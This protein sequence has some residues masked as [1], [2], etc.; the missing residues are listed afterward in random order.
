M[1]RREAALSSSGLPVA[2][3]ATAHVAF[4]ASVL[5]S[6]PDGD[7][8]ADVDVTLILTC[9]KPQRRMLSW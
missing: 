9:V 6:S 8:H 1:P 3:L 4:S 7:D 5:V 2:L